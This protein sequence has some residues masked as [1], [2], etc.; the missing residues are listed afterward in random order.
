[1]PVVDVPEI[2]EVEFPDSMSGEDI[3]KASGEL[4][5][6]K[7]AFTRLSRISPDPVVKAQD[8]SLPPQETF[9][10]NL[11]PDEEKSF[12]SWKQRYAPQDSGEDYDLRGAFKSGY[13]PDERGHWPDTFKKP[14]HP[15]FSVESKYVKFAPELAGRWE[16]ETFIPPAKKSQ[17]S[18]ELMALAPQ[19]LDASL[20]PKIKIPFETSPYET[21]I[22]RSILK[23]EQALAAT[24]VPQTEPGGTVGRMQAAFARGSAQLSESLNRAIGSVGEWISDSPAFAVFRGPA[25]GAAL[26]AVGEAGEYFTDTANQVRETV[27][28]I[29]LVEQATPASE[30]GKAA[31]SIAGAVPSLVPT[32][33]TAPVPGLPIV[34]AG[35][36]TYGSVLGEAEEGFRRQGLPE[37]Q[38]REKSSQIA[39]MNGL[40]TSL[41][42]FGFNRFGPGLEKWTEQLALPT[43]KKAVESMAKSFGFEFSEEGIDQLV[44]GITAKHSYDPS[45]SWDSIIKESLEAAV[46][47]GTLAFG[48]RGIAVADQNLKMVQDMRSE[49]ARFDQM[50]KMVADQTANLASLPPVTRA[51]DPIS[52]QAA[53]NSSPA[54]ASAVEEAA[55]VLK[56]GA[57]QVSAPAAQAQLEPLTLT[58]GGVVVE[59]SQEERQEEGL[60]TASQPAVAEP[61]AAAEPSFIELVSKASTVTNDELSA[62]K[63]QVVGG[64]TGY[65]WDLGSKAKTTEDVAALRTT[66]E[67]SA[68]RVKNL[69]G[70][71]DLTA[72][73]AEAGRQPAEAYEFATG[74]KLDGTPKW[75]M[76]EKRAPGYKPS[77]PD[78]KWID[79]HP[80]EQ[81]VPHG[82]FT[83]KDVTDL[84]DKLGVPWDYDPAFMARTK[85]LTG[86]THLSELSQEELKT[87]YDDLIQQE[88][89]GPG[90]TTPADVGVDSGPDLAQLT[91]SLEGVSSQPVSF[92]QKLKQASGLG[93][94]LDQVK[95]V[96]SQAVSGIKGVSAMLWDK[97]S[98]PIPVTDWTKAV[99]NWN[100]EDQKTAFYTRKFIKQ[101]QKSIPDLRR[102]E[103][104]S[105]WIDTGGNEALLQ[106]AADETRPEFRQGYLDAMNLTPDELVFARNVQN[107][108][109][110]MLAKAQS[111]GLFEHGVEN[112]LH[113]IYEPESPEVNAYVQELRGLSTSPGLAK[114]RFYQFDFEAEK[115]GKRPVKDVAERLA[116]YD[117]AFNRAIAARAFVKAVRDLKEKDG[118]PKV[119]VAGIGV[120][121]SEEGVNKSTLVKPSSKPES[122]EAIDNRADYI[123]YD[124][125]AFRKWK[126]IGSD[127]DGKPVILQGNMLVHPDAVNDFKALLDRSW[128]RKGKFRRGAM[129]LSS[130]VKQ[131][132]LSLSAF[133]PVQ[134]AT[135][136]AEHREVPFKTVKIDLTDPR[137]E[138]LVRGGLVIAETGH[139]Q[140]FSEGLS[141]T[142]LTE[143]IPYIGPKL[144]AFNEWLFQDFI[145]RTKM[146]MALDALTRNEK[147]FSKQLAS[148]QITED[149]L[150]RLTAEQ[151]NAAFGEQNYKML[152][153]HPTYQDTLR[154]FLL[155]PDFLE[156]RARFVGQAFTRYGT[157]QRVALLLGAAA[158]YTIARAMNKALD[159]EWH[160]D[161]PFSVIVKGREYNLRTVQEDLWRAV[162][163]PGR[164]AE[165]RL[166]PLYARTAKEF[167]SGRDWRGEKRTHWEQA[168]DLADQVV[169]ISMSSKEG[170]EWWYSLLSGMGVSSRQFSR[171]TEIRQLANKF[172]EGKGME[173]DIEIIQSQDAPYGRLKTM[174]RAGNEE[175][176]LEALQEL[177]KTRADD[178]IFESM[179]SARSIPF[180]G[181]RKLENQFRAGLTDEQTKAYE[182]AMDERRTLYQQFLKVWGQRGARP[183]TK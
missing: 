178:S 66:A 5:D 35:M 124:H 137:Q 161:H 61:T 89:A 27:K 144:H 168:Q 47:G 55:T 113:R 48:S 34:M 20:T 165:H 145:P 17:F 8:V 9:N 56:P 33:A 12:Q 174:L 160:W 70:Q 3:T 151:G 118:R 131:T 13:V 102:R 52:A 175:G 106:R 58:K 162:T 166:N 2:G 19:A 171:Q 140:S 134:I 87:V 31:A 14:N 91:A 126:W 97:F 130:I 18:P 16:G 68:A 43:T 111:E 105:N 181:S 146:T 120:P 37:D 143:K 95:T 57:E 129:G 73:M 23:D 7:V 123:E 54:T 110:S 163:D 67:E 26:Q 156:A 69:V 139:I 99:G 25:T 79:A 92:V 127:T 135:H 170:D 62:Y 30:A 180:T 81:A 153:R 93:Q 64:A 6:Q 85:E 167:L 100:F 157:E 59:R 158:L 29:S 38:V 132:K 78:Q 114:K 122:K 60:L 141:G 173:K 76:F 10:T 1:M 82:T 179:Q 149:Q 154:F 22:K 128:W 28:D 98:K 77:V 182:Q 155:A 121:V 109:D 150:Y 119:D 152:G 96:A 45:K 44:Q 159:D 65:M 86:K 172:L 63:G 115:A 164:F 80:S 71:G 24:T 53:A 112:Y 42:T 108:F 40:A 32:L 75:E 183:E 11:T 94:S 107:Y 21:A 125:P 50:S 117:Q 39:A 136:A 169:P 15:T 41:L 103:A 148:G 46:A 176:A 116:A 49:D 147:R 90:G 177:R 83:E 74:V 104:I 138:K 36:Q 101:I 142:A 4:Y 88:M 133:H 51:T 84:A 72:A